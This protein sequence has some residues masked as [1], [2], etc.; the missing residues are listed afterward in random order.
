MLLARRP[1]Y[2]IV[3]EA[4]TGIETVD[5][6]LS[7]SPDIVFLDIRMPELNGI[8]VAQALDAED[9]AAPVIV[10]VTAH[11]EFAL[12]AFDV[13][14]ADYL[15]KPVDRERFNRAL[16]RVETRLSAARGAGLDPAL[17]IVLEQLQSR[18]SYPSRFLVRATRGYYFVKADEVE[19]VDAQ[20]NYVRLHAGGRAHMVR[21]TMKSFE[22]Q[23]DGDR[24]VRIHRSAIV[25]IDCIQRLEPHQHGEYV[26]TLRDGARL[27]SSRAH[28]E[29]LR[30]MLKSADFT[31]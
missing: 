5:A 19:W 15:L 1:G 28:S 27:T 11:D 10:F 31:Q 30:E 24:F 18:R 23:L 29:R 4:S 2:E 16:D 9:A 3:G 6:V 20:G 12:A 8:E 7:L 13:S 21:A 14:A 25:A 22:R 17:R 26:V